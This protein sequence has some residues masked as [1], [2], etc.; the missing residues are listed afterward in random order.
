MRIAFSLGLVLVFACGDDSGTSDASADAAA[1][2]RDAGR[3]SGP[4]DTGP[5]CPMSCT[6]RQSCCDVEGA[7]MCVNS[8]EDDMN[9]GGCG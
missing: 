9:C 7:L 4:P 3:D 1:D 6:A 5:E 8:L 2:A